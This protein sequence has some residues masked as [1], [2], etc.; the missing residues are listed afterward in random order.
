MFDTTFN[1]MGKITMYEIQKKS[2]VDAK[3]VILDY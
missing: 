2:E 3:F 1:T